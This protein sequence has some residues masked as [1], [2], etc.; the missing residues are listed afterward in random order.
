[1]KKGRPGLRTPNP[2]NPG[3]SRDTRIVFGHWS[4][5]GYRATHNV[6]ATDTGCLWGGDMTVLR[7]DVDPPEPSFLPCAGMQDPTNFA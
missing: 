3:S 7:L 2:D 1:M 5:L 6:W 4:T